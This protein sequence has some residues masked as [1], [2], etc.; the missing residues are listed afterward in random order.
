MNR[1]SRGCTQIVITSSRKQQRSRAAQVNFWACSVPPGLSGW[2][3]R[4]RC[5][6]R[7]STPCFLRSRC[8]SAKPMAQNGHAIAKWNGTQAACLNHSTL[9]A[10]YF[11]EWWGVQ[12]KNVANWLAYMA[13][14]PSQAFVPQTVNVLE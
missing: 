12:G 13:R 6:N 5:R 3:V 9:K 14:A 2:D 1:S 4:L 7:I 11:W 8:C 10:T